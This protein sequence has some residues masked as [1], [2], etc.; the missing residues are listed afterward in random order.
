MRMKLLALFLA[1]QFLSFGLWKTLSP[2]AAPP[3]LA[4]ADETTVSLTAPDQAASLIVPFPEKADRLHLSFSTREFKEAHTS[5]NSIQKNQILTA[6]THLPQEHAETVKNITLDYSPRAHRG[7]GGNH[8]IIMRAVNMTPSEFIAVLIHEIGHN[9]DYAYLNG[10]SGAGKS[11]FK[12]GKNVIYQNDLSAEFYQISWANENLRQKDSASEDFVSGYAMSDPFEDFAES[13][14]FY[15]L[16]NRDFKVLASQNEALRAKYQ[17]MKDHV[18]GGEDFDTGRAESVNEKRP[19]D[20]T[21]LSYNLGEFM[22]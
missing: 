18:F 9:V 8:L 5:L 21:L 20:A 17:F 6:M 15:R 10:S 12:D 13:Y 1:I 11:A 4:S 2:Q 7:L 22:N 14:L 16:H 3:V 19:W